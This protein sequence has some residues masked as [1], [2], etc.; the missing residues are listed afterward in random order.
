MQT[1]DQAM[2]RA[3]LDTLHPAGAVVE[4][5]MPKTTKRTVSGYYDDWAALAHDAATWDTQAPGIY[6]TLNPIN[7]ALLARSRNRAIPYCDTTTAD[8]DVTARRWL[9]IDCDSLRPAGIPSTDAEHEAALTRA[10]AIQAALTARGWPD[11]ILADSGNGAHLLYRVELPADDGGLVARCLEALAFGWDDGAVTIDRSVHNP[12]RIWKLYGTV[13]RKGD[14]TTERPQRLARLIEVP[15]APV[16]VPRVLLDALAAEVPPAS[17]PAASASRGAFDLPTWIGAHGLEVAREGAWTRGRRWVLA[18]CPWNPEHTDRSAYIIQFDNGAIGA[19][20]H[21][22][23][24]AGKGWRE[25]RELLEPGRREYRGTTEARLADIGTVSAV[26]ERSQRPA[27]PVLHPDALM[28]LPGEIVATI[29]PQTEADP[30]A[31]LIG[32][33]VSFGSVVGRGPYALADAARHGLNEFAV[34]VGDT[35]KA[36]KD[37][38]RNRIRPLFADLDPEWATTRQ[39]SGLSSGE[40]FI[41]AVRDPVTRRE[42]NRDTKEY[43]DVEVDPGVIDKRLLVDESEFATVLKVIQRESN[44][45]SDNVRKAWDGRTLRS[46]TRN[47]PLAATDPHIAVIG[48]IT[49][50]ELQK[51]LTE[52]EAAN[53]FLNR[54]LIVCARRAQ[55]LPDGGGEVELGP[56]GGYLATAI[57]V[58]RGAREPYRRDAAATALWHRVYHH[59]ARDEV[60]LYAAL[61]ARAEAHLLRLSCLYAA[62]DADSMVREHHLRAAV[63]LWRYCEAS[64]RFLFGDAIG[65]FL[66]DRILAYLRSVPEGA[67]RTDLHRAC[68]NNVSAARVDAAL[69]TLI[70]ARRVAHESQPGEGTKPVQ[71]YRALPQSAWRDTWD[72][73]LDSAGH[74]VDELAEVAASH[75]AAGS[76]S[77]SAS[78]Y[79]DDA[80]LLGRQSA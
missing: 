38:A 31:L 22:N 24:C 33:L 78:S 70:A 39:G 51:L 34:I 12:A 52:T 47:S 3:A 29:A 11:P 6:V 36:R 5:R 9:P 59:L 16:P 40:G 68:G 17:P 35:A 66:A 74:E 53:G 50:E 18:R 75:D 77:T 30:V 62:L 65:D 13:A 19:G 45:L 28:G 27:W 80:R 14:G 54:F 58:A 79:H 48:N 21:H 67:S 61:T 15:E 76:S 57:A 43:E 60:G 49:R 37:T 44:T 55:L 72:A 32:L 1:C 4:L 20:C 46:M 26:A 63:A 7:P 56:F 25:L 23:S 64:V 71:W 2:I 10:V 8:S 73:V 69:G 41:H 42:K